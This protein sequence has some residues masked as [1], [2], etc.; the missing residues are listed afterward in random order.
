MCVELIIFIGG[1]GFIKD[2][3]IKEIIVSVLGVELII[4]VEVFESI[5]VYFK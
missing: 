1:F 2:D 5:E 4:N 3:L